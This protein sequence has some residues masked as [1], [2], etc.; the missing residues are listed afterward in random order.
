MTTVILLGVVAVD[1][2]SL[3]GNDGLYSVH[4]LVVLLTKDYRKD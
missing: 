3:L 1:V 2:S 4:V